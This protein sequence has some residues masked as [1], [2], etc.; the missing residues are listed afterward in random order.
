MAALAT[1]RSKSFVP[2]GF[3]MSQDEFCILALEVD[4]KQDLSYVPPYSFFHS[5]H[6]RAILL[7]AM[8]DFDLPVVARYQLREPLLLRHFPLPLL[9]L[10][11]PLPRRQ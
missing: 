4:D 3:S 5:K 10:P 7:A 9:S 11:I 8:I 1:V 2:L 6:A